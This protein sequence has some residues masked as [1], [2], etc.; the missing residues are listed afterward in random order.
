MKNVNIQLV[1][2]KG[3]DML[4]AIEA[5][6]SDSQFVK[7]GDTVSWHSATDS[8]EVFFRDGR[9]PQPPKM[10]VGD[11]ETVTATEI[12]TFTYDVRMVKQGGGPVEFFR[13]G[14]ILVVE[15]L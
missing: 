7:Q 2:V 14:G 6:K 10:V 3:K 13:G 9:S 4:E 11:G 15:P 5:M 8:V 1:R 12:G